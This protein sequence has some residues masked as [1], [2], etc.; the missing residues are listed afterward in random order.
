MNIDIERII[1]GEPLPIDD[2][3]YPLDDQLPG[4]RWFMR[5]PTDYEYDIALGVSE[6]A[7]AETRAQPEVQAV[8]NLPPTADWIAQQESVRKT[9]QDRIKELSAK[10]A[11]TPEEEIELDTLREYVQRLV[12]PHRFNR[13]DEIARKAAN[14]ARDTWFIRRLVVDENGRSLFDPYQEVTQRRWR[15]IGRSTQQSLHPKLYR[16]LFLIQIAKNSSADQSSAS[17]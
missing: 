3:V 12:D 9:N 17:S 10:P 15:K 14:R 13:A 5:Q 4:F 11:R 1:N 8:A 7:E 16:V 6:A 2:V